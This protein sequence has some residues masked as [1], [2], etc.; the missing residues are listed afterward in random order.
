M[1]RALIDDVVELFGHFGHAA[2]AVIGV[3][4][5]ARHDQ[6]F[7]GGGEIGLMQVQRLGGF[8][9]MTGAH[10]AEGVAHEGGTPAQAAI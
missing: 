4:F 9:E 3:F 2:G 8:G 5:E 10:L 6:R 7:G 1:T